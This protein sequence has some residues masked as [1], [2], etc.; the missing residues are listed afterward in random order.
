MADALAHQPHLVDDAHEGVAENLE[1]HRVDLA[2]PLR[3][4]GAHQLTSPISPSVMTMFPTAST[5][6][7][8]PGGSTTVASSSSITQGPA[9]RSSFAS[10]LR[11][12][13]R[14]V[15]PAGPSKWA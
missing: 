13:T 11:S 4:S 15:T 7:L 3:G 2:G 9:I 10:V 8:V 14:G 6:A 12:T 1:G 5:A